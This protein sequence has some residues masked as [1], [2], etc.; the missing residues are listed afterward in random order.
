M[1]N[2]TTT[3]T[4]NDVVYA[5]VIE[6]T[7]LDYAHDFTVATP[8]LATF[9]LVGKPSNVLQLPR[10]TSNM[11]VNDN[12][13]STDGEFD[14]T[15]ATDVALTPISTE[16]VQLTVGEYAF[17]AAVTDNVSEDS[18]MGGDFMSKVVMHAARILQTAVETDACALFGS[19]SN[20]VGTTNTNIT[21]ANF[22]AM[23][24]GVRTRGIHAPNGTAVVWDDQTWGDLRNI[25]VSIGTSWTA[26]PQAAAA[27]FN[28]S[29]DAANGL[30]S[31]F[32]GNIYNCDMYSSGLTPN[33][34][35][36]TDVVSALFV[37]STPANDPMACFGYVEK[38]PF[39]IGVERSETGRH[40][41]A[42]MTRRC[43]VGEIQDSAGTKHTGG[44]T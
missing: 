39:R 9:S 25:F 30:A 22:L 3:T 16:N 2:E 17:A 6:D 28:V 40:T 26:Y 10:I 29:G 44:A 38:R 8:L 14:A 33:A 12:G 7:F 43:G 13:G 27:L 41:K 11:T 19:L 32:V 34:N 4:L 20:G 18:I 42:V 35:G 23:I 15:E 36:T 31:G 5:A 1:A 24:D 21:V 37:H